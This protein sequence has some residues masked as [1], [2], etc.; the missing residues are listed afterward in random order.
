[1]LETLEELKGAGYVADAEFGV[2]ITD[3]G[4]AVRQNIKIRPRESLIS[5]IA[6]IISVK[7]DISAK[8]IFK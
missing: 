1:M 2:E 4:R 6:K 7:L 3:K 8:D 5:K